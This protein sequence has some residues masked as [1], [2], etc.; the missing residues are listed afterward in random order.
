MIHRSD[1]SFV[2]DLPYSM[3][4]FRLPVNCLV[5][6]LSVGVYLHVLLCFSQRLLLS[7]NWSSSKL[8]HICGFILWHSLSLSCTQ[9]AKQQKTCTEK[10][11]SSS[12]N[13]FGNNLATLTD[14]H[15]DV[16]PRIGER[17]CVQCTAAETE[18]VQHCSKRTVLWTVSLNSAHGLNE[19][20]TG[21]HTFAICRAPNRAQYPPWPTR[22][23]RGGGRGRQQ[24]SAIGV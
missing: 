24:S 16:R 7:I 4:A 21:A 12:Y 19:W 2:A 18:T 15:Q 1:W 14:C 5:R 22:D 20:I 23:S 3:T 13:Q 6:V 17:V 11:Q 10:E 8:A 9:S